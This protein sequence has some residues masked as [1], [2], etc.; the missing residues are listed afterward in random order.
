MLE[1]RHPIM[2]WKGWRPLWLSSFSFHRFRIWL[3]EVSRHFSFLCHVNR[4]GPRINTWFY[5]LKNSWC[6]IWAKVMFLLEFFDHLLNCN[7]LAEDYRINN[8]LLTSPLMSHLFWHF[9]FLIDFAPQVLCLDDP[10]PLY[11]LLLFL[12][13]FKYL[14]VLW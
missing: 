7:S 2:I 8:L 5:F 6:Q 9:L 13:F 11:L 12:L 4:F 1:K 3:E 10:I 14:L